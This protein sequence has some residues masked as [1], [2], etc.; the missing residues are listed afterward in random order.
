MLITVLLSTS[1]FIYDHYYVNHTE[2]INSISITSSPSGAYIRL[3]CEDLGETPMVLNNI[4]GSHKITLHSDIYE[5]WSQA[6]SVSPGKMVSISPTLIPITETPAPTETSTLTEIPLTVT[7]K[8]EVGQTQTVYASLSK[9]T[10]K[11]IIEEDGISEALKSTNITTNPLVKLTLVGGEPGAFEV[12][13][14][15]TTEAQPILD[16]IPTTWSWQVTP[17]KSG[18]HTLLLSVDNVIP[19]S[20]NSNV[21]SYKTLGNKKEDIEVDFNT[22]YFIETNWQWFLEII[23]LPLFVYLYSIFKE[24]FK[25][26]KIEK[27]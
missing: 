27:E 20:E 26:V 1:F 9:D 23:I 12:D 25:F 11:N 15:S 5:D 14:V 22:R 2:S 18:K 17:L 8:M 7:Q 24:K 10:Y 21:L 19:F 4:T 16:G 3:D 13:S 6:I